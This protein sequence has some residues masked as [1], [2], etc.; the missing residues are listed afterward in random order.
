MK[1]SHLVSALLLLSVLIALTSNAF[2]IPEL[3]AQATGTISIIIGGST[4]TTSTT[5]GGGGG[6]GGGGSVSTT[7]STTLDQSTTSAA[8]SSD[9]PEFRAEPL[10]IILAISLA[11]VL[12]RKI[13]DHEERQKLPFGV[14]A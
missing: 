5:G 14:Q 4:S 13:A 9:V 2:S 10:T 7:T 8:T 6:G 3:A 1:P 11:L 12:L